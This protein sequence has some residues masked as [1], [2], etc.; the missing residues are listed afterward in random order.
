MPGDERE[1]LQMVECS[2]LT[3]SPIDICREPI[4]LTHVL[5]KLGSVQLGPG[6]LGPG[7]HVIR[8]AQGVVSWLAANEDFFKF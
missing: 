6:Q 1:R 4:R 2:T 3:T 7:A 5:G 8:V